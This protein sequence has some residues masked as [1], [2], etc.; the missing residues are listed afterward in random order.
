MSRKRR[1]DRRGIPVELPGRIFKPVAESLDRWI[2]YWIAKWPHGINPEKCTDPA[3]R[4]MGPVSRAYKAGV[5]AKS[6]FDQ[7]LEIEKGLIIPGVDPNPKIME[8][9]V[10]PQPEESEV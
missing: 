10:G 9:E 7:M 3:L 2:S 8:E 1:K 4:Q 5:R 6:L